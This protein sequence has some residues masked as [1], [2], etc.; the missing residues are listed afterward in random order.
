MEVK[1]IEGREMTIVGTVAVG[2]SVDDINIG[3]LWE[4]FERKYSAI[5]YKI[6]G[7]DYE[8]HFE[9]DSA[10]KRHLCFIGVEVTAIVDLP[11]ELFVKV[12]PGYTYAVFIHC[13]SDGG[14]QEA[15]RQI[16]QWLSSSQY[17]AAASFDIQCYDKRFKGPDNP[18]S[19]L[20]FYVPVKLKN[21]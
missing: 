20:E 14:Y 15:Y 1:M 7:K 10:P 12:V 19:V 16:D 4:R 9:D 3:Q 11:L 2:E 18:E 6:D 13:F 5:K 21:P 8:L 17:Q